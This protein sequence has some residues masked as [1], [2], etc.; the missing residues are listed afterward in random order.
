MINSG[1]T[2]NCSY[3]AFN[4]CHAILALQ[5]RTIHYFFRRTPEREEGDIMG[6]L[7][8]KSSTHTLTLRIVKK[9]TSFYTIIKAWKRQYENLLFM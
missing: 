4:P 3:S 8:K 7:Q 2:I 5:G 6:W 1:L 9:I